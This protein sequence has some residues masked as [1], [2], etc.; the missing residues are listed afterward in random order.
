MTT[1]VSETDFVQGE[2][3]NT[4]GKPG[5]GAGDSRGNMT[6]ARKLLWKE[7]HGYRLR[8]CK[9]HTEKCMDTDLELVRLAHRELHGY[10][11]RACKTRTQRTAWIQT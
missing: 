2:R 6:I 3:S 10:G 1:A 8:A 9:T 11:L 7:L 4:Y 5:T